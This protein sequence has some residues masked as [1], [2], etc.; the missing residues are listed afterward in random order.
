M[1][2]A[3]PTS[4]SH[5]LPLLLTL[6]R[7]LRDLVYAYTVDDDQPYDITNTEPQV[8]TNH[9]IVSAEWLE[10]IYTHQVCSVTFLGQEISDAKLVPD[11]TWGRHPQ[12][13]RFVR[14]LIVNVTESPLVSSEYDEQTERVSTDPQTDVQREWTKLLTLPRLGSLTINM[15]KRHGQFFVF[16]DFNPVI[17]Q[18]REQI[19]RPNITFCISFDTILEQMWNTFAQP[20]PEGPN[21]LMAAEVFY[22]PMGFVD[23]S[24]LIEPPTDKDREYVEEHLSGTTDPGCRNIAAG[25][26]DENRTN[27]RILAPYYVVK[28]PELLRVLM[29]E[30]Y[31]FT[32]V[33][34]ERK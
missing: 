5:L 18:L 11:S 9:P 8:P 28:E 21:R 26:L 4:S 25:L 30:H 27:R 31:A 15:Q 16:E 29:A 1:L 14:R 20:D 7:E 34:C 24:E 12:Y 23:V 17:Y 33:A 2:S 19:P 10:A 13:K 3:S 22:K 32:R 6:P